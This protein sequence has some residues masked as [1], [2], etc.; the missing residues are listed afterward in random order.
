[1]TSKDHLN[2]TTRC[3]EAAKTLELDESD[4]VIDI[5]GDEPLLDPKDIDKMI[6]FFDIKKEK[7]L[8]KCNQI[9]FFYSNKIQHPCIL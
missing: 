5:Q 6:N 9:L 8:S 2:G 4:I 1:M 7:K 3:A